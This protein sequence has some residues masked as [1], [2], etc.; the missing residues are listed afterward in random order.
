MA[1]KYIDNK[2]RPQNVKMATSR[3]MKRVGLMEMA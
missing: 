3:R 2:R 1:R